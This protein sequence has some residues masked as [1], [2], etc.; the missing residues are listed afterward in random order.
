MHCQRIK[1]IQVLEDWH[2][3]TIYLVGDQ[4]SANKILNVLAQVQNGQTQRSEKTKSKVLVFL[5]SEIESDQDL[6]LA[7][8]LARGQ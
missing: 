5:E 1:L 3:S 4:T 7:I 6:L 2:S 8:D